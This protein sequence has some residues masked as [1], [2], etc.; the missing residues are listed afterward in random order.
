MNKLLL[1]SGLVSFTGFGQIS[2][3]SASFPVANDELIMST[4]LDLQI[5]YAS[6]GAN[7]N[8][9][10][11]G[12]TP[13]GQRFVNYYPMADASTLSGFFF[14]AFAAAPYKASY[15]S[16]STDLPLEQLT[17]NLPVTLSGISGFSKSAPEAVTMVGWEF[18]I[19]GTGIPAKSDTIETRYE[20]PLDYGDSYAS[21]GYTKLNMTPI[22]EA[23]WIQHRQRESDVD[24]WGSITTPYGTFDALRIHHRIN[25]SDSFYIPV[26]GGTWIPVPVPE[27][28]EYEWRAAGQHEAI[29]R[30]KTSVVLGTETVTAVE[31]RDWFNPAL[32]LAEKEIVLEIYPNPATDKLSINSDAEILSVGI[33]SQTGQLVSTSYTHLSDFNGSVDLSDLDAG[34]YYVTVKTEKGSLTRLI[35][36]Q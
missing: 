18:L 23:Q 2:L 15:F 32:A 10:F 4:L 6:T 28:H 26:N 31:Y 34:M 9:D 19:N 29:L 17:A 24:G 33:F 22:Y 8:W 16:P 7:Y 1:L 27:S 25:E 5:D 36:I 12:L 13:S 21:R 14:G 3:T 11:S 35:A 20:F 30:I